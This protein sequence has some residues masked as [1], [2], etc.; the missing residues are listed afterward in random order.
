MIAAAVQ[1]ALGGEFSGDCRSFR[2]TKA[3]CTRAA[4]PKNGPV[5]PASASRSPSPADARRRER[6]SIRGWELKA[7]CRSS[8]RRGSCG[9]IAARR[10]AMRCNARLDVAAAC[11]V[12]SPGARSRQH[13]REGRRKAFLAPRPAVHRG[14]QR[15]GLRVDRLAAAAF[16]AVLLVGHP[17]KLAKLA[18]GQWDTH[19]ARSRPA[20]E[21]VARLHAEALARPAAE[22]PTVEGV[23]AALPPAEKI[24][25]A[26]AL[27]ERI[28]ESVRRRICGRRGEE[29]FSRRRAVGGH[30]RGAAGRRGRL[31]TMAMNPPQIVVVGCGPGAPEYLTDAARRAVAEAEA[32]V[33]SRRLLDLFADGA[34]PRADGRRR[35]RCRGAWRRSK[36]TA[37]PDAAW[38]CWSAAIRACSASPAASPSDS[39]GPIAAS[40]RALAPCNWL[41]PGWASIGA[42][43][44]S[45]APTHSAPQAD[46]EELC[47][48]DKLAV[49][50]GGREGRQ[51][52]ARA[53]AALAETHEAILC[54]NL[55]LDNERIRPMTPAEL[56]SADAA[57]LCL[58][59]FIRRSMLS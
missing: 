10:F 38:P 15:L 37:P 41:S 22:S 3:G 8:A 56:A 29:R 57:S 34:R 55:S 35:R 31:R 5:P 23:F 59:L 51:W 7:A 26:D 11:G 47:R 50:G 39:A 18:A 24:L 13:R 54:E 14:R 27:A 1:E 45:S 33:G 46:V 36:H 48:F 30:V 32:L 52:I 44:R 4:S 49:L 43:R 53:A 20:A 28:R 21:T 25:L 42:T 2:P 6:H 16:E 9:R 19:W 58:V 40:S 17:G 12:R